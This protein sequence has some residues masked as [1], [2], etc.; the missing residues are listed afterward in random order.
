M[1]EKEGLAKLADTF[2]PYQDDKTCGYLD[3]QLLPF[4]SLLIPAKVFRIQI[5]II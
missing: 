2:K 4:P 3:R 5:K 1:D